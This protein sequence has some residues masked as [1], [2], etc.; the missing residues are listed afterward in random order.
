[1]G[2]DVS[3]AGFDRVREQ[4]DR[5]GLGE[6]LQLVQADVREWRAVERFD[7]V[8]SVGAAYAFGGVLPTLAAAGKHLHPQGRL[9]LGECIWE[10]APSEQVLELLGEKI[11][12]YDDLPTTVDAVASAGWVP[13][14]GHVSSLQEWDAYEW[15]WTGSLAQWALDHPDNPDSGPAMTASVEH[16]RAW[17]EGYRGTLGFLKMLLQPS[18]LIPPG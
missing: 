5:E 9:L 17:L 10:Q 12:D 6:R 16:R 8:L 4:A 15:S 1:M 2:V 7:V 18:A 13:L 14:D 11:E 3:G